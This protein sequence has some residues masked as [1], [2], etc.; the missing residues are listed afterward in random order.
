MVKK[1][2]SLSSVKDPYMICEAANKE[3]ILKQRILNGDDGH[4]S[5]KEWYCYHDKI[6]KAV[7][8]IYEYNTSYDYRK[9]FCETVIRSSELTITPYSKLFFNYAIPFVIR[10]ISLMVRIKIKELIKSIIKSHSLQ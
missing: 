8:V 6:E 3:I 1:R 9:R 2:T 5:K 4:Q 10:D 7:K